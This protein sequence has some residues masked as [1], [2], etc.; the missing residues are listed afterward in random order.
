MFKNYIKI[1]IRN[2][3]KN[4]VYSLINILG[5]SIGLATS[6]L[7]LLYV[8]NEWNYDQF[9]SKSEQLFRVVQT[10]ESENNVESDAS[11]P[12]L[13]GPVLDAEF[14]DLINKSVRFYNLQETSHTFRN[15]QKGVSFTESNFYFVDSTFFNVFSADLLRGSPSEVL[16]NPGSLVLSE[17][18]SEK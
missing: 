14:P 1:A 7:I 18:L 4:K 17:E 9:H 2:L 10:M 15:K 3:L 5:L 11:T 12:F 6:L 8:V 16:K 13:L